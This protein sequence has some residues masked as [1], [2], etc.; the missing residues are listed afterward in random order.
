MPAA[1]E[2]VSVIGALTTF[3]VKLIL[4]LAFAAVPGGF[5][6]W[7]S[8]SLV[9]VKVQVTG[10]PVM[11]HDEP[12][13][14]G[15]LASPVP[16][17]LREKTPV[18]GDDGVS[19]ALVIRTIPVAWAPSELLV[20]VKVDAT[21]VSPTVTAALLNGILGAMLK[22]VP[23]N[24]EGATTSRLPAASATDNHAAPKRRVSLVVDVIRSCLPIDHLSLT[25]A[26]SER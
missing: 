25:S 20:I 8:T 22:A 4:H 12:V 1:T 14:A 5:V 2:F 10:P 17:A 21:S 7:R 11:F 23:A 26:D 24:T 9:G 13:Q 3:T 18:S 6:D 15:V 16:V 19:V